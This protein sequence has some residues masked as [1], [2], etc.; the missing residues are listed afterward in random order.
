MAYGGLDTSALPSFLPARALQHAGVA[1]KPLRLGG[2]LPAGNVLHNEWFI[3]G[4]LFILA[5]HIFREQPKKRF[6]AYTLLALAYC[7]TNLYPFGKVSAFKL[8]ASISAMLA[9]LMAAYCCMT[10]LYNG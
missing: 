2:I 3:F 6:L 9:A 5:L 1:Y 7:A 4:I 10:A 8:A